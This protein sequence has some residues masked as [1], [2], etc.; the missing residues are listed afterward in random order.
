MNNNLTRR[1]TF[2]SWIAI[3]AGVGAALMSAGFG[4]VAL[5]LGVALG[6]A[7]GAITSQRG[8]EN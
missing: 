1:N 5:A 3:G 6:A 7:A 2:G 8:S 4:P